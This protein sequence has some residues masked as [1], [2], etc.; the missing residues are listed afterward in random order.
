M[1]HVMA[2]AAR[3][4]AAIAFSLCS[5]GATQ[6][7][8]LTELTAT[9]AARLIREGK[10]NSVDLTAALLARA[11]AGADLHAFITLDREGALAAAA[12]ADRLRSQGTLLGPL[13]GGSAS[14]STVPPWYTA[15]PGS[16]TTATSPG[17]STA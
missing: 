17:S 4:A 11:D 12:A 3:V 13:H 8:E 7:A 1:S 16:G 5:L 14:A 2:H 9:E 6:A 10:L 15:Y